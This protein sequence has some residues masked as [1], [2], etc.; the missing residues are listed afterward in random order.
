MTT[1]AKGLMTWLSSAVW[2]A[3]APVMIG[4]ASVN[5]ILKLS[6]LKAGDIKFDLLGLG[7]ADVVRAGANGVVG[8]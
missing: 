6:T 1:L 7:R 4:A 2:F 8:V 3:W 5:W